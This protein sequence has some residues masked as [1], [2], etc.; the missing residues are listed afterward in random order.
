MTGHVGRNGRSNKNTGLA[1]QWPKV[2]L[3]T[4]LSPALFSPGR[5]WRLR[6]SFRRYAAQSNEAAEGLGQ[7]DSFDADGAM[8]I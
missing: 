4:V 1:A 2:Q 6:V 5:A 8:P 3:M 7:Q